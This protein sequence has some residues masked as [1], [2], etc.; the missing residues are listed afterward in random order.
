MASE[1]P[2][3][4]I[5]TMIELYTLNLRVLN[6]AN[7]YQVEV[8]MALSHRDPLRKMKLALLHAHAMP[9]VLHADGSDSGGN[10]FHI[11]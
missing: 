2:L 10:E 4:H 8:W 11:R 1:S 9:T 5:R 7:G 3:T 6:S